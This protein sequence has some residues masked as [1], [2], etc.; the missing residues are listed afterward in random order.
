MPV[1]PRTPVIRLVLALALAGAALTVVGPAPATAAAAC[2]L[3]VPFAPGSAIPDHS[4][5]TSIINVP[6]DGYAVTDVEVTVNIHEPAN[7]DLTIT[8][9]SLTDADVSR[10]L[11]TLYDGSGTGADMLGTVFDDDAAAPIAPGGAPY[12]GRFKPSGPGALS[13]LNGFAGGK[14]RLKVEDTVLGGGNGTL[15]SW[16]LTLRYA[17]CDLDSDTVED[18][19]DA[20]LGDA[21]EP[22]TGCPVATRTLSA[23]YRRGKFKGFLRSDVATCAAGRTVQI[24]KARPGPDRRLGTVR[25]WSDGR[26]RLVRARHAGRY[27]ATAPGLVVAGVAVCPAAQSLKFR[28]R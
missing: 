7:E 21:G 9:D 27:Y 24:W 13:D 16:T 28:I 2:E 22:V 8:L 18:H 3:S 25:T 1:T 4:Y 17:S 14:Y 5:T 23:T 26:Y 15:D 12:A 20:C 6:E 19:S 11:V 10:Q